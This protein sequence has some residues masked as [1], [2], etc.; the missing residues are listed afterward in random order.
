MGCVPIIARISNIGA[1]I[2]EFSDKLLQTL[3]FQ[4]RQ[5][6]SG[7]DRRSFSS[8]SHFSYNGAMVGSFVIQSHL[9]GQ[10]SIEELSF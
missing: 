5:K 10:F 1:D 7:A 8:P 4:L 3:S 2:S 6:I 9:L